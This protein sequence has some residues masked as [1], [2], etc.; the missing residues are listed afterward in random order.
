MRTRLIAPLIALGLMG[1]LAGGI[2]TVLAEVRTDRPDYVA[3]ETVHISGD[4]M[5]PGEMVRVQVILPNGLTGYEN[6]V[7]AAPDGT[8]EDAYTIPN[9]SVSG[10]YRVVATGLD[11]GEV[12]VGLGIS[13]VDREVQDAAG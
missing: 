1:A 7:Q 6:E 2:S 12:F 9:P 5:L 13:G 10:T 4:G 3:G 11:S 8:F